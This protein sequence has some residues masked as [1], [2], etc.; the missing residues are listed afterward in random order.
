M[1]TE[2]PT[3]H[4]QK[5]RDERARLRVDRGADDRESRRGD[6]DALHPAGLERFGGEV[7]QR[8]RVVH[9]P[10]PAQG[11]DP[12]ITVQYDVGRKVLAVDE[13]PD[14]HHQQRGG[15]ANGGRRPEAGPSGRS[16]LLVR[17]RPRVPPGASLGGRHVVGR[18]PVPERDHR[19]HRGRQHHDRHEDVE[20]DGQPDRNRPG[21]ERRHDPIRCGDQ[22]GTGEFDS[23]PAWSIL[24]GRRHR[25]GGAPL[26]DCGGV[27]QA[28]THLRLIHAGECVSSW[29]T[30][31]ERTLQQ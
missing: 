7:H 26:V 25:G 9:Q 6:A 19:E 18:H 31:A 4:G 30:D 23:A 3:E 22:R 10:Q 27:R 2:K 1:Q 21:Q 12:R 28:K 17:Y 16:R 13:D 11:V 15:G 29:W 20:D 5:A 14:Q 8:R 24:R